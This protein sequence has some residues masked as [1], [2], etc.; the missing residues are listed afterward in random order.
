MPN[1]HCPCLY[2]I[3]I[4]VLI[5]FKGIGIDAGESSDKIVCVKK[6]GKVKALQDE[7][8]CLADTLELDGTHH[9][10]VGIAHTRWA[11]HGRPCEVNSH[12]QVYLQFL[13]SSIVLVEM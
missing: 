12:P 11:T 6:Q 7:I 4:T 2:L 9:V 13:K 8:E 3:L 10:H 1:G 5:I